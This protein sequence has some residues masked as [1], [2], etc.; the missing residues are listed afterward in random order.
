MTAARNKKMTASKKNA[1]LCCF[2]A[3]ETFDKT[4]SFSVVYCF[5]VGKNKKNNALQSIVKK[6]VYDS[7]RDN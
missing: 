3:R 2:N 1:V 6:K 7:P 5:P 4:A